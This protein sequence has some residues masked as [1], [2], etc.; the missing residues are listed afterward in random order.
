MKST[1]PN[2][3]YIHNYYRKWPGFELT[4][5]HTGCHCGYINDYNVLLT[6]DV[7]VI[8][9]K[10]S[11]TLLNIHEDMHVV[12]LYPLVTQQ[13]TRYHDMWYDIL[14]IYQPTLNQTKKAYLFNLALKLC[15]Y[16][17]NNL[18]YWLFIKFKILDNYFRRK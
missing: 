14:Y 13:V 5:S 4:T 2:T 11:S 3:L 1:L 17:K 18:K 12:S 15:F 8:I 6:N 10:N 16:I 9:F 7:G